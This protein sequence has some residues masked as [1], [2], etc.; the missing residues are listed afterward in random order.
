MVEVG[1]QVWGDAWPG[2]YEALG[3]NPWAAMP[4]LHLGTSLL[5]AML[6]AETAPGAGAVGYAYAAALAVALLYLGEHYLV[7]LVAG[8]GL[9]ACVRVG[10]PILEP[11][12]LRVSVAIQRLE[13]IANG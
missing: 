11:A 4:S 10:E 6:L 13:R 12:A 7:D 5:A 9:V 1:E 8:I 3:G 2:L